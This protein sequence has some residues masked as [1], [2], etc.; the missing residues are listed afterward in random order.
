MSF[1]PAEASAKLNAVKGGASDARDAS[2]SAQRRLIDLRKSLEY[3]G[4]TPQDAPNIEHE[5]ARLQAVKERQNQRQVEFA[6]LGAQIDRWLQSLSRNVSLVMAKAV[7]AE[8]LKNETLAGAISRTRDEITAAQQHLRAVMTA[9]LPKGDLKAKARAHARELERQGKPIVSIERNGEVKF[10]FADPQSFGT[11][12]A[13]T[14]A[15]LAW[16]HPEAMAKRLEAEIEALPEPKLALS[17]NEKEKRAG[18]LT[19]QLDKLERTE[20]ALIEVALSQ[21]LDVIRRSNASP[22]AVLGV[23]VKAKK[24]EAA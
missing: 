22:A 15:I 21:G 11:S 8:P 20:E 7:I 13:R 23:V 2:A 6:A 16:L 4:K 1:L 17:A 19:A 24:A 18:E 10:E 12:T 9:P 3:E 14:V 5:I